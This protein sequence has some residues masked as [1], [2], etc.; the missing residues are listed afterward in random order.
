MSW[1]RDL[2]RRVPIARKAPISRRAR[3]AAR[4]AKRAAKRERQYRAFIQGPIWRQQKQRVHQRDGA[5]CTQ[6]VDGV[7][8]GYTKA[9]GPLHAHHVRYHP[10]GIQYTPDRDIVTL[11]P[12]HHDRVEARKWWRRPRPY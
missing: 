7:R 11:C 2:P 6:V 12:T 10:R 8:C 5:R 1:D 4:N 9:D 3:L